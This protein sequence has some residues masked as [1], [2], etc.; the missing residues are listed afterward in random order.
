MVYLRNRSS[1]DVKLKM[2]GCCVNYVTLTFDLT[3]DR[4]IR[5]FNVIFWKSCISEI[6]I[7]LM[8][9]KKKANQV[10]NDQRYG[11]ALWLH[12]LISEMGGGGLIDME[13]KK[14]VLN[15]H[16]HV[17]DLWLTMVGS[18]DV[19]DSDWVTSDVDVPS[20]C[21]VKAHLAIGLHLLWRPAVHFVCRYVVDRTKVIKKNIYKTANVITMNKSHI[22]WFFTSNVLC[23]SSTR[24]I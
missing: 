4:D 10:D 20:T 21:L 3:H 12:S 1:I 5:F 9:S 22:T 7:Y 17:C 6:V 8:W 24:D 23:L 14:Y 18:V 13:Q 11:C 16:N 2:V 19:P 15:I